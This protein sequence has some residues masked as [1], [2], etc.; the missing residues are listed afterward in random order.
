[1][2]KNASNSFL[3]LKLSYINA[4]AIICEHYGAD[5][6]E[7]A[8]GIG[9]DRRIGSDFLQAGPGWGGSCLPKDVN[10][11]AFVANE[12]GFSFSLLREV[13][14]MNEVVQAHIVQKVKNLVGSNLEGLKIAVWGL[15]FKPNTD[16]LRESPAI[17]IVM[18]LL[19]EGASVSCFDPTVDIAPNSIS[20]ASIHDS[21]EKSVVDADLILLLTEW[22]E[23]TNVEPRAIGPTMAQMRILDCRNLLDQTKWKNAGFMFKALGRA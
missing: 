18:L 7:V 6:L 4:I 5:I 19:Q 13:M 16:D 22:S 11:L 9:L 8:R 12:K 3:A 2:I 15:T 20:S 23:F 21:I 14:L 10:S 1:M 17:R